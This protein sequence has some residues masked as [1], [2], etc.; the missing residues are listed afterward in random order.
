MKPSA[1]AGLAD[2]AN[3]EDVLTPMARKVELAARSTATSAPTL[4]A[5]APRPHPWGAPCAPKPR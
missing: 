2:K 3:R 1:P 5:S 4:P